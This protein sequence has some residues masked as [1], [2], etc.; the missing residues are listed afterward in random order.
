MKGTYLGEFE[1][2]VL[3]TVALLYDHAYGV[4]LLE[5]IIERSGRS[6]SVGALH[7]ALERLETKGFL[8][9]R[10]GEATAERGGRR[11][12]YFILTPIGEKALRD[13]RDLRESMWKA[14]PQTALTGGAS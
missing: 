13:V 3:L 10:M 8:R 4:A 12:R 11:K 9:S 1:E 14:I 7:S 5:E 2:L 6:V